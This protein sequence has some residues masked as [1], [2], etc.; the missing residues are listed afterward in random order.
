MCVDLQSDLDNL[1][2]GAHHQ[3][4]LLQLCSMGCACVCAC[5]AAM[6][7]LLWSVYTYLP[8]IFLCIFHSG[9]DIA[10]PCR[11]GRKGPICCFEY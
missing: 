7:M 4:A 3:L 1:G 10:Q 6:V 8:A 2:S 5:A 9:D 11:V